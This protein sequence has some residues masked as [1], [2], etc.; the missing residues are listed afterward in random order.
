MLT[1]LLWRCQPNNPCS[2][3]DNGAKARRVQ[4]TAACAAV[5]ALKP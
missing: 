4:N 5:E 3:S 2:I 1:T